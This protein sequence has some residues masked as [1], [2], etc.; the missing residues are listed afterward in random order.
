MKLYWRFKK[1]DGKWSY[2]A[3]KMGSRIISDHALKD[4]RRWGYFVQEEEE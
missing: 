2:R 4:S 3:A 1:P